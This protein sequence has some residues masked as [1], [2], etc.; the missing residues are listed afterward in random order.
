MKQF[1]IIILLSIFSV[2]LFADDISIILCEDSPGSGSLNV[3]LDDFNI[4]VEGTTGYTIDQWFS[5][6]SLT[7]PIISNQSV[8]NGNVFYAGDDSEYVGSIT[9]TVND[10]DDAS[11]NYSAA[12]FCVSGTDPTPAITGTTGGTFTASPAGLSIDSSTGTLSTCRQVRLVPIRLL[13]LLPEI[14]PILLISRSLSAHLMML[15]LTTALLHFVSAELIRLLLSPAQQ[16]ELLRLLRL[17]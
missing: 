8:S 11:F 13:T 9:F 5:D 17:G 16:V 12:A 7:N 1:Y 10:L 15:H 3:N 14:A 6:A 2:N 4:E